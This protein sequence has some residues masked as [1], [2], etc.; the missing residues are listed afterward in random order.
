MP[1]PKSV[2]SRKGYIMFICQS[3]ESR[4]RARAKATRVVTETRKR[5]YRLED[6]RI[7]VGR[8]IVKELL[9]CEPCSVGFPQ[10]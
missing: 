5:E 6:G 2:K 7:T 3:C 4:E 8:E 1:A 10:L 9:V